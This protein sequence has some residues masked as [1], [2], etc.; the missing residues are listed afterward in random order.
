[1]A[2][3]NTDASV[4]E[5]VADAERFVG[6]SAPSRS[7]AVLGLGDRIGILM[8]PD[9][10]AHQKNTHQEKHWDSNPE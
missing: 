6:R 4:V 3:F 7:F 10:G 1:M 5:A 8:N 2:P 9:R